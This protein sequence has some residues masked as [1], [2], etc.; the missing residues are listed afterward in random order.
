M[1]V[2]F[3]I[4]LQ[5]L[6][7]CF[8]VTFPFLIEQPVTERGFLGAELLPAQVLFN[9]SSRFHYLRGYIYREDCSA[10]SE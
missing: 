10:V 6:L 8:A 3:N 9:K 7:P 1:Y 2:F 4:F 5:G